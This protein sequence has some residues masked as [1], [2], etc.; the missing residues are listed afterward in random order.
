MTFRDSL[1]LS[2][3]QNCWPA[4]ADLVRLDRF[5]PVALTGIVAIKG[6][7]YVFGQ[8]GLVGHLHLGTFLG[9]PTV[10]HERMRMN[11]R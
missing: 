10:D 6:R 8:P 5:V 2:Q 9:L 7:E 3:T 1:S 11:P 4:T